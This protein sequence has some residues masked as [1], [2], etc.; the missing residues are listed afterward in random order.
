MVHRAF[1]VLLFFPASG[2]SYPVRFNDL[3]EAQAYAEIMKPMDHV[4]SIEIFISI[5]RVK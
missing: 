5:E 1:I 3:S 2:D 4:G